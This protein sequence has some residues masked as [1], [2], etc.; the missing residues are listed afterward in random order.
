MPLPS[1]RARTFSPPLR[2]RRHRPSPACAEPRRPLRTRTADSRRLAYL[3]PCRSPYSARRCLAPP[4]CALAPGAALPLARPRYGVTPCR[5][6]ASPQAS[7]IGCRAYPGHRL[8][9]APLA[10]HF[11]GDVSPEADPLHFVGSL[12]ALLSARAATPAALAAPLVINTQGWVR[13]LGLDLLVDLIRAADPTAVLQLQSPVAKRNLPE[14]PFWVMDGGAT[15]GPPPCRIMLLHPAAAAAPQRGAE[16]GEG[17]EDG[18]DGTAA[19]PPGSAGPEGELD[20]DDDMWDEPVPSPSEAQR[21][22]LPNGSALPA[23]STPAVVRSPADSRALLW[24]AWAHC[25][26][27]AHCAAAAPGADGGSETSADAAAVAEA[28]A[29][30]WAALWEAGEA[31][32]FASVGAALAAAPPCA[33][34]CRRVDLHALFAQARPQPV[35]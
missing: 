18:E 30:R 1:W 35:P 8:C 6:P 22:A 19:P 31:E 7:F 23:A 3:A 33:V 34:P 17:D 32:A 9:P 11:V 10:Q 21:T 2:S 5:G 28:S 16:R 29:G 20:G 25:T 12:Q 14:G 26:A 4:R 13:G 24:L 15:G 27:E